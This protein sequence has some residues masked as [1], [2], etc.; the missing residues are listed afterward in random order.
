MGHKMGKRNFIVNY[1]IDMKKTIVILSLLS[2]TLVGCDRDTLDGLN[3]RINADIQSDYEREQE[4]T[5]NPSN[6][7]DN[8]V[9]NPQNN[10]NDINSNPNNGSGVVNDPDAPMPFS[11]IADCSPSSITQRTNE[12]FYS[13]RGQVKSIDSRNEQEM[14]AWK[15]IHGRIEAQCRGN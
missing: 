4:A 5:E 14:S 9:Q 11:A 6:S 13:S 8:N 7:S 15:E 10:S 3:I 12:E 1:C 2:L